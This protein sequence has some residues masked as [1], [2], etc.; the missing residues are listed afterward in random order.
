MSV[1]L[2]GFCTVPAGCSSLGLL[3]LFAVAGRG[4]S[5]GGCA[6]L[7]CLS[8]AGSSVSQP[9]QAAPVAPAAR[10]AVLHAPEQQ[11]LER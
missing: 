5:V 7:L 2:L 3:C 9:L 11:T 4:S 1:W 10:A 6:A 8:P